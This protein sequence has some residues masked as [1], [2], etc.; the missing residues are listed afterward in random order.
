MV[1]LRGF[2]LL[3][4]LLL[5]TPWTHAAIF[6]CAGG[7]SACL[8]AAIDAANA[9]GQT[10]T[11]TLAAGTYTLTAVDNTA[12]GANGLPSITSPLTLQ[13]A[14]ASQTLIERPD[15]APS[16]R[17]LH[18]AP[19]G[20][21]TVAGVTLMGGSS[22]LGSGFGGGGLLNDGTLTLTESAVRENTGDFGGGVL[23]FGQLTLTR[24]ILEG[25][26]GNHGAGAVENDG[27]NVTLTACTLVGNRAPNHAGGLANEFSGLATIRET[28]FVD[29]VSGV[30]GGAIINLDS[31]LSLTNSTIARNQGTGFGP[32]ST[33][34]GL[35][36][37][38][39]RVTLVSVTI[40]E[41]SAVE[42][43]GGVSNGTSGFS[44][45]GVVAE[46]RIQYSGAQRRHVLQQDRP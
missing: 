3:C 36:T 42:G 24:T 23:N 22:S 25:N 8:I 38:G 41:N 6:S 10:N 39:G 30:N 5:S 13:G 44:N 37:F 27:G 26:V 46:V 2:V 21:L 14:G 33:G 29:N 17:L 31:T 28:T 15:S 16:F 1:R 4:T 45:V 18:I 9:N 32:L 34:G 19:M 12:D 43:G 7:D 11:I 40:A 35:A 20:T